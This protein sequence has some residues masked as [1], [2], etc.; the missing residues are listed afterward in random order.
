MHNRSINEGLAP[1]RVA[2][3]NC[4]IQN[5]TS[6]EEVNYRKALL[7]KC[8]AWP[9]EKQINFVETIMSNSRHAKKHDMIVKE[10]RKAYKN[11]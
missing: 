10:E 9:E 2:M 5:A 3:E 1:N 4:A 7:G 6:E 8:P 11:E